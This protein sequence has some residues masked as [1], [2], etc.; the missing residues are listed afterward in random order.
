MEIAQIPPNEILP[1][2]LQATTLKYV[3]LLRKN[4]TGG[5]SLAIPLTSNNQTPAKLSEMDIIEGLALE[6]FIDYHDNR[7]MWVVAPETLFKKRT[8]I[9]SSALAS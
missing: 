9:V 4:V 2:T 3:E 6:V 1:A 8:S 7:D 5:R